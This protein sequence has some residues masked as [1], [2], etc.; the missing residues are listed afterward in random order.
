MKQDQ[1]SMA[2]SLESRVPLLDHTFVEFAG[3]V[4]A[5]LK[6]G[7]GAGKYILKKAV[8]GLLPD[9]IIYRKKMGFPTPVRKW[10]ASPRAA[11]LLS[12]LTDRE[13]LLASYL[14]PAALEA[15]LR[16]HNSGALDATDR[17][18]RLLNLQVWGDI[19]ITG[20]RQFRLDGLMRGARA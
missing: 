18:W 6:L 10:L 5:R 8:E 17:I 7:G 4:P 1:M 9:D 20:R 12:I 19:F 14:D 11:T 16:R 13:G 15:L 2:T 3:A